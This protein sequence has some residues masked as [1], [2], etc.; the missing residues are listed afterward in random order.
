[1]AMELVLKQIEVERELLKLRV[2]EAIAN[3]PDK[4]PFDPDALATIYPMD[5]SRLSEAAIDELRTKYYLFFPGNTLG[6]YAEHLIYH[7]THD[8]N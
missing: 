8:S 6:E 3:S 5:P 2:N 4:E 1:M 7:D